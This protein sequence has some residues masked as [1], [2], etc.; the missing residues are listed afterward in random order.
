MFGYI[1]YFI[2]SSFR[3]MTDL[4]KVGIDLEE[5][6]IVVKAKGNAIVLI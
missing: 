2:G 1:L 6:P 4:D 3:Y 5:S